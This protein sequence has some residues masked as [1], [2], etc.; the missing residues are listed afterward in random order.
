MKR[1]PRPLSSRARRFAAFA[2]AYEALEA[3]RD[4]YRR[5]ED[6]SDPKETAL[7]EASRLAQNVLSLAMPFG[8]MVAAA[9]ELGIASPFPAAAYVAAL[10]EVAFL[11][12]PKAYLETHPTY[13][14]SIGGKPLAVTSFGERFLAIGDGDD[15]VRACGAENVTPMGEPS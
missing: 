1:R 9:K 14:T 8:E 12:D 11:A 10:D 4:R 13:E 15:I 5:G 2:I 6:P 3:A 7:D